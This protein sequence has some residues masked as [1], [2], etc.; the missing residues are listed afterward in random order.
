MSENEPPVA[1][2]AEEQ[3]AI[4]KKIIRTFE[5]FS[6]AYDT[7]VTE[8]DQLVCSMERNVPLHKKARFLITGLDGVAMF[9]LYAKG[10]ASNQVAPFLRKS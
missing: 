1:M 5:Q 10:V 3:R 6:Q 7:Y 9:M 2:T 4:A 8:M